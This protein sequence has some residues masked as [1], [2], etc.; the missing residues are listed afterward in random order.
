MEPRVNIRAT[1]LEIATTCLQYL[2]FRCFNGHLTDEE[3]VS[4]AWQG[5]YSFQDFATAY[6]LEYLWECFDSETRSDLEALKR[7]SLLIDN[8][9]NFHSWGQGVREITNTASTASES[10]QMDRTISHIKDLQKV[11]KAHTTTENT[12]AE[13]D[14]S[15]FREQLNR[16]RSIF[17]KIIVELSSND[18]K[19]IELSTFYGDPGGWFKC[20]RIQCFAF[21]EGF[22][23]P[24]M[25]EA[26]GKKHQRAFRCPL[27]A[28]HYS[29]IG[30]SSAGELKRHRSKNHATPIE[31]REATIP[32]FIIPGVEKDSSLAHSEL[33]GKI[34]MASSIWYRD[35][36][37]LKDDDPESVFFHDI[38]TRGERPLKP[39]TNTPDGDDIIAW[40]RRLGVKDDWVALF[41]PT[42]PIRLNVELD[43]TFQHTSVVCCVSF[44]KDGRYLAT[45]CDNTCQIFDVASG[46]VL[47]ISEYSYPTSGAENYCRCV[48]FSPNGRWLVSG[49]EEKVSI[50]IRSID[51]E[52][53]CAVTKQLI[54]HEEVVYSIDVSNDNALIASCSGDKTV[55]IWDFPMGLC[56]N[57]LKTEAGLTCVG[58]TPDS[59][60]VVATSLDKCAYIWDIATGQQI[61]SLKGHTDSVYGFEFIERGTHIVTAALDNAIMIWDI[62]KYGKANNELHEYPLSAG[63]S[64]AP[65]KTLLGHSVSTSPPNKINPLTLV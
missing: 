16:R 58:I 23:S 34:P 25:K 13:Q 50:E 1:D 29:V 22:A 37:A 48:C 40:E 4:Y 60:L 41:D 64:I 54:G 27:E 2:C 3:I 20:P 24:A 11:W 10:E 56:L 42:S 47:C 46:K 8:F 38:M 49:W 32:Q 52:G 18:P 43:Y 31:E 59:R 33:N 57:T 12:S 17:E 65:C 15:Y 6:W 30:F 19:R 14:L 55:K 36:N 61:A 7:L 53:L 39:N 26:H 44:S 45:G 5:Y 63:Q 62:E 51:D 28:C 9:M 21:H 35:E